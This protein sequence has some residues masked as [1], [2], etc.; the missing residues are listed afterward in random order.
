MRRIGI[1]ASSVFI[2]SGPR[3]AITQAYTTNRTATTLTVST[4]AGYVAGSSDITVTVAPGV[5]I[6]STNSVGTGN[7]LTIQGATAGD[8]IR[9][10]NSGYIIGGGG[11]GGAR[12]SEVGGVLPTNGSTALKLGFDLTVENTSTGWI[13][14]GGGGGAGSPTNSNDEAVGGGGGAGG[15]NGGF[16]SSSILIGVPGNSGT[17]GAGGG[18]GRSLSSS[19]S[20]NLSGGTGG[21][22]TSALNFAGG[23]GGYAGGGG[24]SGPGIV[25]GGGGGWGAPGGKGYLLDPF[26]GVTYPIS[27]GNGGSYGNVG[28]DGVVN[29]PPDAIQ[30]TNNGGLGGK[31]IDFNGFVC[32]IVGSQ[33]HILGARG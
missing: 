5:Y 6:Y 16:N 33:V 9:L 31:A 11:R 25:G 7:A 24:G 27:G 18:G 8:T 28:A 23:G 3:V 30:T 4:L 12:Q 22:T 15:G 10:I 20:E 14:G 21:T 1:T 29:V 2:N 19:G 32:T 17:V 13:C 26:F